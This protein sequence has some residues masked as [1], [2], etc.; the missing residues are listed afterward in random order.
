M[1]TNERQIDP[2][3]ATAKL[4]SAHRLVA[5][6]ET[7]YRSGTLKPINPNAKPVTMVIRVKAS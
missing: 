2:S 6:L 4:V 3:L 1:A 5:K 7:A